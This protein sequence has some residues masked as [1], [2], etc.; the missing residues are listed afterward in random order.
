MVSSNKTIHTNNG[1]ETMRT[2]RKNYRVA[3]DNCVMNYYDTESSAC[4]YIRQLEEHSPFIAK[5]CVVERRDY[6]DP[7]VWNEIKGELFEFCGELFILGRVQ[8]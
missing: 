3:S 1:N 2:K 5:G 6:E 4:E 7:T 8:Y